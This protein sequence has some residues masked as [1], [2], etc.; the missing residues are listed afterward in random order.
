LTVPGVVGIVGRGK[1][2]EPVQDEEMQYIR[3]LAASDVPRK[4]SAYIASGDHIRVTGGPLAGLEGVL[5]RET[6]SD[7]LVISVTLLQRS[8][9]VEMERE[10]ISPVETRLSVLR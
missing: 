2:P 6:G 1:V 9:K 4:P 3:T 5:L 7:Y 8:L 10:W